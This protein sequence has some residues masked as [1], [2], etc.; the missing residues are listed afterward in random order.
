M[1]G[2]IYQAAAPNNAWQR[3]LAMEHAARDA[4]LAT[5]QGAHREYLSGPW[6]DHDAYSH[7]EHSAWI[8]YY[9]AG[10]EAWR[11]YAREMEPPPPPPAITPPPAEPYST[12]GNPYMGAAGPLDRPTFTERP[13]RM[14]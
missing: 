6:P 1:S 2:F 7:V 14:Q 4:Y 9:A 8:T 12:G 11:T 13:E 10:R 5:V 3:Y